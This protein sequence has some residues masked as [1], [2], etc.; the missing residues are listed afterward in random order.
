MLESLTLS[1]DTAILPK[2]ETTAIASLYF[3]CKRNLTYYRF[4]LYSNEGDVLSVG[5]A[6]ILTVNPFQ[7]LGL[8]QRN[9][10]LYFE[11]DREIEFE[12]LSKSFT[13]ECQLGNSSKSRVQVN[14]FH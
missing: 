4:N 11:V 7:I 1:N 12:L 9:E 14:E 3:P 8:H 6:N 5:R 2:S 10:K 13:I